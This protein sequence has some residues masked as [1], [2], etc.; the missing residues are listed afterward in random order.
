M[1]KG[2]SP[3]HSIQGR[4]QIHRYL[5]GKVDRKVCDC[6]LSVNAGDRAGNKPQNPHVQEGKIGVAMVDLE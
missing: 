2:R 1:A 5:S 4:V 6:S 3:N